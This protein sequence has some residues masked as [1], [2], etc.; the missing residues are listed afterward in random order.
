[1]TIPQERLDAE[2]V[3][4]TLL[5]WWQGDA[6]LDVDL[7]FVT[8]A[9]AALPLTPSSQEAA[10]RQAGDGEIIVDVLT[11]ERG[12][13]VVSQTCDVVRDPAQRPYVEIAPLV[14]LEP[15]DYEEA[16]RGRSLRFAVVPALEG[17]HLVAD[18][19]RVMTIEK[20]LL[21]RLAGQNRIAGCRD[22]AER[23]LLAAALARRR[24]RFAFPD[25]FTLAMKKLVS[26]VIAK[27]ARD[28]DLGRFLLGLYDLRVECPDWEAL[29]P[30]VTLLF[31][32]RLQA[33]IPP[34][35][36]EQADSLAARFVP[37][38]RF[39]QIRHQVTTLETMTAARHLST[40]ALDLD[41]L[42]NAGRLTNDRKS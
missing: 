5:S 33:D 22:D 13:V 27:H 9:D 18:L 30:K 31:V 2:S 23:R 17:R 41:H 15:D 1:M 21:V 8:L 11:R 20:P 26:H 3:H 28:S 14:E 24:A 39:S 10:E 19:D 35:S 16:R 34:K 40:D 37:T 12:I 36:A 25:D 7:P 6:L 42:S 38:G 4:A 29:E 32:F